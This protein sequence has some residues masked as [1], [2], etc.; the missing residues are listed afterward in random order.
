MCVCAY[1]RRPVPIEAEE[2][3][4]S[5]GAETTGASDVAA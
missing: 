4:W 5:P 2:D 3:E 1:A